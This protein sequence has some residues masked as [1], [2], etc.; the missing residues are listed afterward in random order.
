MTWFTL[1]VLYV[2]E[3]HLMFLRIFSITSQPK[4]SI[5][6]ASGSFLTKKVDQAFDE[7]DSQCRNPLKLGIK[8]YEYL[9]NSLYVKKYEYFWDRVVKLGMCV[10]ISIPS[11]APAQLSKPTLLAL[12]NSCAISL[13]LI[14]ELG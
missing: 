6:S 9:L 12:K 5:F 2:Q 14:S 8:N 13:C 1:S 3:N 7:V 11:I 10:Q 4:L